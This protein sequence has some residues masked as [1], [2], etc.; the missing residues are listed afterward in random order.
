MGLEINQEFKSH[1]CCVSSVYDRQRL[2]I[3]LAFL[4]SFTGSLTSTAFRSFSASV[5][6]LG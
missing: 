2:E 4:F 5:E 3:L 6:V 1:P